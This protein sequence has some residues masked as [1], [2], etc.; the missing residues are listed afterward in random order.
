M[1]RLLS[2]VLLLLAAALP[3]CI[4]V[5]TST[6]PP[7]SAPSAPPPA[8]LLRVRGAEIVDGT[9]R[10][11]VL[12]GVAFGNQVWSNERIPRKHHGEEDFARLADLGMNAVRFY[13]NYR[14]LESDAEP[15]K[16]LEDGFR[17][18]DENMAWARRTTAST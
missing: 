18:L 16:Y 9:G 6:K 11:V 14:T 1:P 17:W 7:P 5:E 2:S 12:R 4:P 15:G 13:L 8:A 10:A 3:A